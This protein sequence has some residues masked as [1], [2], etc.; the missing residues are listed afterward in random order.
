MTTSP[1]SSCSIGFAHEL[2]PEESRTDLATLFDVPDNPDDAPKLA[3][4]LAGIIAAVQ[5]GELDAQT[6]ASDIREMMT[7]CKGREPDL[8]GLLQLAPESE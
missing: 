4:Y 6:A 8:D 5:S 7:V 2:T 1:F 3:S